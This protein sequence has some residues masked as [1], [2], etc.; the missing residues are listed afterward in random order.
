MLDPV[1]HQATRLQILALIHRNR[2]MSFNELCQAL[3]LTEGNLG[4]H[5]ERLMEAQYIE[6]FSALAGT[7]FEKRYRLTTRGSDAFRAYREE[8][9][10][11]LS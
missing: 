6:T 9:A 3:H 4:A 8:L 1:I 11:L 5:A 2:E 7:R 10:R